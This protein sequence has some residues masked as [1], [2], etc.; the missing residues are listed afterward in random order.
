MS[1]IIS[2]TNPYYGIVLV[3]NICQARKIL[4]GTLFEKGFLPNH[5]PKTLIS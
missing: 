1:E 3:Q 4:E 5:P 2:F